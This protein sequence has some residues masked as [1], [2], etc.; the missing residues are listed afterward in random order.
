[1]LRLFELNCIPTERINFYESLCNY[2]LVQKIA[3]KENTDETID[4]MRYL[5]YNTLSKNLTYRLTI[6][7]IDRS[8]LESDQNNYTNRSTALRY[9]LQTRSR[10]KMKQHQT[11][12][13]N[14]SLSLSHTQL[15]PHTNRSHPFSRFAFFIIGKDH[16]KFSKHDFISF[17]ANIDTR[18]IRGIII[19]FRLFESD[20][21]LP[22][23]IERERRRRE[24]RR[25]D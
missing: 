14:T 23:S 10:R 1:M 25:T 13:T 11:R 8:F 18:N 9:G 17:R 21:S 22:F 19:E 12:R 20:S 3:T 7:R 6:A 15:S 2:F 5:K 4:S 24:E 16:L